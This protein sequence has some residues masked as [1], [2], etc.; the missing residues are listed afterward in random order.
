MLRTAATTSVRVAL[1]RMSQAT[2]AVS[3]RHL[4]LRRYQKERRKPKKAIQSKLRRKKIEFV[5]VESRRIGRKKPVGS[6]K[7]H[8][9]TIA[10][11]INNNVRPSVLRLAQLSAVQQEVSAAESTQLFTTVR[12]RLRATPEI[13]SLAATRVIGNLLTGPMQVRAND[14]ATVAIAEL[15]GSTKREAQRL[16]QNL[17]EMLTPTVVCKLTAP[18]LTAYVGQSVAM[19]V[20]PPQWVYGYVAAKLQAHT[21]AAVAPQAID[22]LVAS[23]DSLTDDE[24]KS[25]VLGAVATQ[26]QEAA[27]DKED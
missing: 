13:A 9:N 7:A 24:L 27:A 12:Q 17:A 16:A 10:G 5:K 6:I 18:E 15:P 20:A 8:L 22:A 2:A 14:D 1:P 25:L 19:G 11:Q 4:D 21:N 23:V 26:T 3:V